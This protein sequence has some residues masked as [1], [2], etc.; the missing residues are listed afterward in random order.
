MFARSAFACA[1]AAGLILLACGCETPPGGANNQPLFGGFKPNPQPAPPPKPPAPA[2]PEKNT[3][4]PEVDVTSVPTRDDITAVFQF[5]TQ[6]PWVRSPDGRVIGFSSATYFHSGSTQKGVFVPGKVLVWL[7]EIAHLP[8]GQAERRPVKTW[9]LNEQE[10]MGYRLRRVFQMGYAYGL[11]FTWPPDVDLSGKMIEIMVGYER[12]DGK[13]VTGQSR[14]F[15]VPKTPLNYL[16][17]ATQPSPAAPR[18]DIQQSARPEAEPTRPLNSGRAA[19]A[20]P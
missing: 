16:P 1:A 6:E 20:N 11:F 2:Q 15:Q 19:G 17:P 3:P 18:K 12:L 5:Y 13:T 10:A 8:S 7:Y 14:R 9:E 4:P